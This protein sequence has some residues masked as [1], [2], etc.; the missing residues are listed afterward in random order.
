ML[1]GYAL[2]KWLGVF[3]MCFQKGV[4]QG[5]A[6]TSMWTPILRMGVVEIKGRE[7]KAYRTGNLSICLLNA[8]MNNFFHK[9]LQP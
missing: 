6:I 7:D 2:W 1:D 3:S 8:N 4:T 9:P 5:E